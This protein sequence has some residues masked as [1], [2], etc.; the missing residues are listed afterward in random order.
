VAHQQE[1]GAVPPPDQP[2]SSASESDGVSSPV[3]EPF[4]TGPPASR[5]PSSASL[6]SRSACALRSR[7]T[8]VKIV[9]AG[10]SRRASMASGFMSGC[11]IFH[12]PDICST[13]SRESIRTSSAAPGVCSR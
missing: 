9:P 7:G 5:R 3:V 1:R 12:V 6:A 11:L 4:E 2:R 10:A 13:T 8:Q